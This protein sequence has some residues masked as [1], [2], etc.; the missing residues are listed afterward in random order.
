M[1]SHIPTLWSFNQQHLLYFRFDPHQHGVLRPTWWG[2]RRSWPPNILR[3]PNRVLIQANRSIS[4][5]KALKTP[6][7]KSDIYRF[8]ISSSNPIITNADSEEYNPGDGPPRQAFIHHQSNE[9]DRGHGVKQP[10]V[11]APGVV[12]HDQDGAE[13]GGRVSYFY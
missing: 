10:P 1:L 9:H 5:S 8:L 4:L 12:P 7:I 13:G 6:T 11:P 3:C 2:W